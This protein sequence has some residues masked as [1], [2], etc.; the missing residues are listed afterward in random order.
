MVGGEENGE[1]VLGGGQCVIPRGLNVGRFWRALEDC[2]E[3]ADEVN[4]NAAKVVV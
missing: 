4:A 3:R 1:C 2:L